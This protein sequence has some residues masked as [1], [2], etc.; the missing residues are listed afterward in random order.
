[1]YAEGQG[2]KQ[3]FAEAANWYRKAADQEYAG[4]QNELGS[5]YENGQGVPQDY[6]EAANWYRKAAGHGVVG[7]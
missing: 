1:L 6:T 4:A 3:D 2:V 7:A 5:L